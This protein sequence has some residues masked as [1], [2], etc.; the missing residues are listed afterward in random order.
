MNSAILGDPES[1]E[2]DIA[3]TTT[4]PG[5]EFFLCLAQV[6]LHYAYIRLTSTPRAGDE[7]SRVSAMEAQDVETQDNE[8]WIP[9]NTWL[10][11][12]VRALADS[13]E[14]CYL[15]CLE[16]HILLTRSLVF[17]AATN[18]RVYSTQAGLQFHLLA[19]DSRHD[20]I[21]LCTERILQISCSPS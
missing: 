13:F 3:V 6:E 19:R 8:R 10:S 4:R 18:H 7:V 9:L 12:R 1:T 14:V 5:R 17:R 16:G 15:T 20:D 21:H 11:R 2:V